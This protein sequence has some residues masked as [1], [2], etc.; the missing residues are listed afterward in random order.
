MQKQIYTAIA[1][2]IL[3]VVITLSALA[4]FIISVDPESS[5][6][7]DGL[8]RPLVE[9]PAWAKLFIRED[10][11]AGLG[12]RLIDML[13]LWG[14][15]ISAFFIY[16][17]AQNSYNTSKDDYI[18][19]PA[20]DQAELNDIRQTLELMGSDEYAAMT[21]EERIDAKRKLT[22]KQKAE[23]VREAIPDTPVHQNWFL[24]NEFDG[25][26]TYIDKLSVSIRG[27]LVKARLIYVLR[28]YGTDSRNNKPV[29]EMHMIEEYDLISEKF[30]V[31]GLS[32]VYDDSS[33]SDIMTTDLEWKNATH[34]NLKNLAALRELINNVGRA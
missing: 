5:A 8:G 6:V 11:W 24:A 14:G 22:Q 32:F 3:I 18:S 31:H 13:W 33:L 25:S 15:L 9:A 20:A 34:G 23:K 7:Y 19:A 28:P 17:R 27:K 4:F 26:R 29:K 16:G 21:D 1:A 10:R 12:W 30:R 2:A